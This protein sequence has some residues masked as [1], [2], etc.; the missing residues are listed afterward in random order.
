[1]ISTTFSL[2]VALMALSIPVA[3]V[4]GLIGIILSETY[5]FIPLTGAVGEVSWMTSTK[6][7][8]L[9][10]PLYIMMG[11]VLLRAGIAER[12]YNAMSCWLSWLPGGLMHSNF[13]FCGVFAATSGTSTA[14]AATIGTV[15][16][17][18]IERHGYD[19]RLFLGTLAAGGTLGILIPPF[20]QFNSLRTAD[21][22]FDP[23]AISCRIYS[24]Y[25]SCAYVH[26]DYIG[27]LHNFS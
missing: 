26:G 25:S 22:N 15:A 5:S 27:H 21:G 20:N 24:R 17:P 1:M 2:L 8:L 6:F 9:A 12:M 14:T 16:I 23:S 19:K 7:I 3:A 11:E 18:E 10:I 4:M 13:G